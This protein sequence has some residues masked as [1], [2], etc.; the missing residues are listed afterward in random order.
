MP[1]G[2]PAFRAAFVALVLLV[3][4]GLVYAT[5]R[6]GKRLD[7]ASWDGH[8]VAFLVAL[9]LAL[10]LAFTGRLAASGFLAF[11]PQP[12][13]LPLLLLSLAA[14]VAL[15]FSR[16]GA[17]LVSGLPLAVLVGYQGFRIPVELLLHRGWAEG[18]VPVQM[19]YGG[20]N[21]DVLTGVL[22][23]LLAALS[24]LGPVPRW[25]VAV[26]NL[27]GFGLLVNVVGI[28]M[29]SAPTPMRVFMNEPANVWVTRWPWVWL[30]TFLVPV[31]LLGHLLVLRWLFA[32]PGGQRPGVATAGAAAG[33]SG[34]R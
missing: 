18:L 7:E 11:E 3:A 30:P 8:R 17:R 9:A 22:A 32:H 27:I 20:M 12:T 19:T 16:L 31:A 34:E 13:V 6:A 10:W 4:V 24:K 5:V 23:L 15:A 28:A 14:A 21:F 1:D 33:F 29:L 26:W 2:S 25:L